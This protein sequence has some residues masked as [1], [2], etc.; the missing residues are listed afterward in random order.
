[1]APAP[2]GSA[3]YTLS[4][5]ATPPTIIPAAAPH[6]LRRLDAATLRVTAAR[7]VAGYR[8]LLFLAGPEH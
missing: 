7:E 1:M 8:R 6:A 4:P 5:P 3:V 2:D